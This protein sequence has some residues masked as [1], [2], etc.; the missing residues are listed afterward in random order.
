P[1]ML[2]MLNAKP[3]ITMNAAMTWPE[4]GIALLARSPARLP[5]PATIRQTLSWTAKSMIT[6]ARIANAKEAPSV[7]VKVAVWVMNPGPIAEVAIRKIAPST[8]P[9]RDRAKDLARSAVV[10][11]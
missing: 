2:P 6:E 4:N 5:E 8:A 10:P 11:V 9:R 3:P 1:A 7:W